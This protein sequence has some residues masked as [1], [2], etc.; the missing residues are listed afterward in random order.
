MNDKQ[1]SDKIDVPTPAATWSRR[2]WG[3]IPWLFFLLLLVAI[4]MLY[5]RI[6]A[7]KAALKAEKAH[8]LKKERPAL[9]VITLEMAPSPIQDR[10][11]L[12]GDVDPWVKLDITAEVRGRIVSKKVTEGQRVRKGTLLAL[13]D[14]RDYDN[15][16]AQTRADYESARKTLKRIQ[17]L[18]REKLATQA[19]LDNIVAR[20]NA[21]KAAM[22]TARLNA[23]R[24]RIRAPA[25]GVVN[26]LDAEPGRFLNPGQ[27]VAE[28]LQLD[29]VKVRVGIP[30]SDVAAVRRIDH[31]NIEV[32]ALGGRIF[33]GKKY[34]LS[35]A[36][37]MQARLYDLFIEV[38]NPKQAI[39]PGMFV[40]VEII[41]KAVP[42]A[43][44]VPL[45][46]TLARAGG[47]I[48]YVVRDGRAQACPVT[49]DIQ[50]GWRV[51]VAGGLSAGDAVIVVGQRAVHDGDRVHVVRQV[52]R[53]EEIDR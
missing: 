3:I 34:F 25:A 14:A 39:L 4:A 51:Q 35:R 31:F 43:L 5:M 9:N 13:I 24:C 6:T 50:E 27:Q 18:H 20:A 8:A 23:D 47:R 1:V 7:E 36:A 53:I 26:R 12:P 2:I 32:A 19:Q 29:R 44:V 40:R 11:R 52:R 30:E 21:L 46:A 41:K 16:L 17:S 37:D 49:L 15:A 10:I 33:Q 45:Y 42:D 22:D 38:N 48:V 28:I